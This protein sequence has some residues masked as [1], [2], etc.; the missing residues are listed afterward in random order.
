LNTSLAE[1]HEELKPQSI[2]LSFMK[3]FAIMKCFN[4]AG[5]K[6]EKGYALQ[7]VVMFLIGLVFTNKTY[8]ALIRIC[9]FNKPFVVYYFG[10]RVRIVFVRNRKKDAKRQWLAILSTSAEA[11]VT[12]AL[13]IGGSRAF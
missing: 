12:G 7:D 6:K 1:E 5:I 13:P 8:Y 3:R 10:I 9:K 2:I 11:R 4:E